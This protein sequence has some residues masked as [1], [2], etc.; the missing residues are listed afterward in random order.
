MFPEGYRERLFVALRGSWNRV[1]LSG[2]EVVTVRFEGGRPIIEPFLTG[3]RDD[4]GQRF[5]GRPTGLLTLPD[6]SMLISDEE[7]GAIYRV[8]HRR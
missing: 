6:G 3:L 8:T 2:F 4:E 5:F 1:R 7:N